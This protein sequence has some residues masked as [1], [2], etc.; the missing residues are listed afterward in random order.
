[1]NLQKLKP[2]SGNASVQPAWIEPRWPVALAV[3]A[4]FVVLAVLPSRA[5]VL[6]FWLSSMVLIGLLVPIAV[7]WLY[8]G[9]PSWQRLENVTTLAFAALV[10]VATLTGLSVIIYK[11]LNEGARISG[12]QLLSSSV[13]AWATNVISFS[14]LYWRID[15]GGPEGRA[16]E[17][18]ASKHD[19]QFPQT[20]NCDQAP[21]NWRPTYP[22]YLFLS[23]C[24]A[25][26]FSPADVLP[27]T[28]RA[29][30]LMM[31]ESAVSLVTLVI[32]ASRAIGI[33][34]S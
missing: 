24:T 34:G 17:D 28:P 11:I 10:E 18:A 15:R 8:S 29:K 3:V 32:V 23:F 26:A 16:L 33:L 13:A 4:M 20:Q 14:L 1:M 31:I 27:L 12:Q 5:H 25:T 19:W 9:N 6:P 7:D 2:A 21:A 22:D 30:M